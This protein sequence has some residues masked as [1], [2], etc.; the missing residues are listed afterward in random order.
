MGKKESCVMIAEYLLKRNDT[1]VLQGKSCL[2]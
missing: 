1:T 2:L